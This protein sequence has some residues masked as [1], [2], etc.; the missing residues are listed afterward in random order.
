MSEAPAGVFA[1]PAIQQAKKEIFDP[2]TISKTHD[3]EGRDALAGNFRKIKKETEEVGVKITQTESELQTRQENVLVKLKQKLNIS[4]KKTIE[5]QTQLLEERTRQDQLPDP[6]VMVE[7]YYEKIAETP[8]T[9][10]EKRDLLKPEVLSQL[11][12]DEYIALWKRL[13]PYFLSHVTRQGF[14]DHN[15]MFYHSA[16]LQEFHNGFVG[17]GNDEKQLR[18]PLALGELKNRDET[19]VKMFL[20][21]WVLQAENE[22]EAKERFDAVLHKSWASAPKYPDETA[23]HFAT[24]LVANDYYGGENGNEIFFVFPSDI[25]ASQHNFA[26]N[27]WGK[28]FTR[29]QNETKWND[30]FVWPNTLENPGISIDTGVVFL[31]EDTR[32]DPNTGSKYA[33]KIKNV[34]G[35]E[36]RVMIENTELVNKF[37][38]WTKSINNE[39]RIMKLTRDYYQERDQYKLRIKESEMN[40][41]CSEELQKVGFDWES[42]RSLTSDLIGRLI[43]WDGKTDISF[44]EII[45]ESKAKFKKVENPILAKEYWEDFFS[46]NPNLKP[47]HVVYYDGDPTN[48]VY[49]FQQENGIGAADTSK[50]EGK[51]LGFDD[52]H[53]VDMVNDPRASRGHQ[54]LVDLGNKII[55]EHYASR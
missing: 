10:Q 28:D 22:K 17:V 21:S 25:L 27:G 38:E 46:K 9:N 47:K 11:S 1:E 7:A 33:S 6:K 42:S 24:Q 3:Q 31:P 44:Q 4:D 54:E 19:S 49:R 30:V 40:N 52:R 51:L 16:G 41:Y 36:K 55:T 48:A 20:S 15:A 34:D 43:Y 18:P 45:D 2:R 12:M 32:V 50:T 14:R 26:F 23:V 8:L 29:P 37:M 35:Q 5:L 13:N 53:I 39:S